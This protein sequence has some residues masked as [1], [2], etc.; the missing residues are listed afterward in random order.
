MT[1]IQ[2]SFA[3]FRGPVERE[4][5]EPGFGLWQRLSGPLSRLWL[6]AITLPDRGA[7]SR[8]DDVPPEFY[9]FPPF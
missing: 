8:P 2:P 6:A 3:A 1:S 5:F 9:R 7:G 4:V